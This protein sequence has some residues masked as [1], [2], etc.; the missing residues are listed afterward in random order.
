MT[1]LYEELLSIADRMD[2][3][4]EC[5]RRPEIREPLKRLGQVANEIGKAWSG[6]WIGYQANVYYADLQ[7]PPPGAHFSS[8]WGLYHSGPSG[9]SGDWVEFDAKEVEAAIRDRAGNPDLE[10]PRKIWREAIK[11]FEKERSNAISILEVV[12]KSNPDTFLK[13]LRS[14]LEEL[15]IFDEN[16]VIGL[17]RPKQFMSRDPRAIYQGLWTPP[18]FSALSEPWAIQH[19]FSMIMKLGENVRQARS[20]LLRQRQVRQQEGTI[21]TKVF[22]GHGRSPVWRELKDFITERLKLPVD[23]FNRVPIAGMTNIE[24]LSEMLDAATFALL[25]MT[26]E[27]EQPDGKLHARMNVIHEAGLFQGR[28]GFTRAIVLLEEDCEG[29]SNIEGLGQIRFPKGNIRQ[30]FEDIREALE[31]EGVLSSGQ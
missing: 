31:R 22:I 4:A 3:L 20:H 24:R 21:G 7:P 25:V 15:K 23:E 30:A 27:D 29:F 17:Y 1:E 13:G 9:S 11:E 2:Q 16:K 6:S 18:H 8:E 12:V 26:G 14:E 10:S 28:L 5:W 19:T